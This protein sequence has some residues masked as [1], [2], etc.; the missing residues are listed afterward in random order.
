MD[1]KFIWGGPFHEFQTKLK[2]ES[3]SK[4]LAHR[5][6][7]FFCLTAW[8]PLFILS[9]VFSVAY[10]PAL[11]VSLLT[12]FVVWARFFVALPIL[13]LAERVVKFHV[14][15]ALIQLFKTGIIS[16]NNVMDYESILSRIY[17]IRESKISEII[18]LIIAYIST[19]VVWRNYDQSNLTSTWIFT[20]GGVL[21]IPGYWYYFVSAPIFQFFL[22]RMTWKFFLWVYFLY[23]LSKIEL[24]LVATHPDL[25]GGLQ[26]IG[27]T[28]IY[29]GI[30]GTAQCCIISAQIAE[31]VSIGR[32][33]LSDQYSTILIDVLVASFL[34]ML[35]IA[36]FLPKLYRLRLQGKRDYS[37]V[38]MNYVRLFEEKWVKGVNPDNEKILGSS[39]VQSLAD[40]YNSY[41][42][43]DQIRTIPVKPRLLLN[44]LI[45]IAIP[46]APLVFF[47]IPPEE[48]LKTVLKFI[49]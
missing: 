42:I 22:Y 24:N 9:Q 19:L 28:N 47:A 27:T 1:N 32:Y 39:D 46:F 44:L 18:I 25:S 12:D 11:K 2:L 48:V 33:Q 6:L 45:I 49:F 37:I 14:S 21:T 30:L 36:V 20:E 23:K 26:F 3:E 41:A 38:S 31:W 10:N 34:L 17:K 15:R 8:V 40:L 5:K 16:D 29:F 13:I 7:I 43:V 4:T 35:P